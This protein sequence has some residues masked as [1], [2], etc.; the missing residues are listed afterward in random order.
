MNTTSRASARSLDERRKDMEPSPQAGA[1][2]TT[3]LAP[4]ADTVGEWI[5]PEAFN[6]W[7]QL[8]AWIDQNYPG[9][10]APEWLN[11]AGSAAGPCATR[12]RRPSAPSFLDTGAFRSSLSSAERSAR[13]SRS[14]ATAGATS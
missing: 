7:R 8:E 2:L 3:A 12:R 5:G 4:D 10:F 6:R 1:R 11:G 14:A 13:N 9:V